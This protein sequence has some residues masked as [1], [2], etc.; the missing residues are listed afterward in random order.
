MTTPKNKRV[1]AKRKRQNDN[2]E[3]EQSEDASQLS[4]QH[5]SG[6]SVTIPLGVALG[7]MEST[8]EEVYEEEEN[9]IAFLN[10][11]NSVR[12]KKA[13]AVK[14]MIQAAGKSEM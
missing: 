1:Y 14:M 7:I 8:V 4:R 13:R 2:L 6:S 10:R 11:R 12:T 9:E 3:L 5:F